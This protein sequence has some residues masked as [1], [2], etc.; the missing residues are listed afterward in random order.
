MKR[1][2]SGENISY[3]PFGRNLQKLEVLRK[4][5]GKIRYENQSRKIFLQLVERYQ[6]DLESKMDN[7]PDPQSKNT[8]GEF[9]GHHKP[10]HLPN[11]EPREFQA[12][13]EPGG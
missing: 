2:H 6:S 3:N 11:L 13:E 10:S 9:D 7:F 8:K 4:N 12:R 5:L 1:V